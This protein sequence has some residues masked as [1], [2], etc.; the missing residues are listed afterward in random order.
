MYTGGVALPRRAFA[1][2]PRYSA[3]VERSHDLDAA[4]WTVALRA[5][6]AADV[7]AKLRHLFAV[8]DGLAV[9]WRDLAPAASSDLDLALRVGGDGGLDLQ[10]TAA[11]GVAPA[12]WR[13]GVLAL[14]HTGELDG[15][16]LRVMRALARRLEAAER[17][18]AAAA[19]A[20]AVAAWRDRERV[21][22]GEWAT[23]G[24]R[25]ALLRITFRCN[26]DC[27]FCWQDRTWP[28]PPTDVLRGWIDA[29]AASSRTHLTLSGGEPTVHPDLPGLVAHATARG[30]H[31]TIQTNA[32]RLARGDL[33]ALLVAAG[34]RAVSVSHHAADAGLSDVLTRAPGTHARTEAGIAACLRAGLQVNLNC[35]VGA[36][37]LAQLPHHARHLATKFAPLDHTQRLTVSYSHPSPAFDSDI[38][39]TQVPPLDD[40]H[41]PLTAA[42]HT[43][44][45]AG[46]AVDAAGPCGFPL[47]VLRDVPAAMR[48]P[49][50]DEMPQA[51]VGARDHAA[52]CERCAER[53][54]CVGP[55]RSWLERFGERGLVPFPPRT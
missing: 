41:G 39:A 13:G 11:A 12:F 50:P 22:V 3:R 51:H 54:R 37:N 18:G 49:G 1:S 28:A 33:L 19:F 53:P 29:V 32:V 55:R 47:C 15:A 27:G 2:S 34:L 17:S 30:L 31:V 40:V 16:Q 8:P 26:Q 42:L 36:R 7:E 14:S 23:L 43:L 52:C 9:T 24:P 6:T 10:V 46:V 21:P 38:R 25:D 44:M 5:Q 35:V 4:Q 48:G 45:A 20:S